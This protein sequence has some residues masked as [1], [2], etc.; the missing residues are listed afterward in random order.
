M[1][2]TNIYE[3]C[4]LLE[5]LKSYIKKI[6]DQETSKFLISIK[7]DE[8]DD[9]E[10]LQKM[11]IE[12]AKFSLD[13]FG[14]LSKIS[15]YLEKED[16]ALNIK[17]EIDE[18]Y[19]SVINKET[20]EMLFSA[21]QNKEYDQESINN[22]F[23]QLYLGNYL[24]QA[25]FW[26]NTLEKKIKSLKVIKISPKGKLDLNILLQ[27]IDSFF[28]KTVWNS[29]NKY[30]K[31]DLDDCLFCL[32]VDRPTPS[33][34]IAMRAVE[35]AVRHYYSEILNKTPD[36]ISWSNIINELKNNKNSNKI[37]LKYID[38]LKDIRNTLQ[39]PDKRLTT[40]EAEQILLHVVEIYK[41]VYG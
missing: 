28:P 24:D 13:L 19:K 23:K 22:F 27:G 15:E 31:E 25:I 21:V 26:V 7:L 14:L 6:K 39:H 33:G 5:E 40:N 2:L 32:L 8:M 4:K 12:V 34:M 30:D 38:Y 37:L 36:R 29:I 20:K 41:Q 9:I 35:S 10:Q 1:E 17:V 11:N 3:L 18:L 16:I